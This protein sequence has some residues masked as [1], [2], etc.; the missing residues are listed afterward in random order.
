VT[1]RRYSESQDFQEGVRPGRQDGAEFA[2]KG[3]VGDTYTLLY[4]LRR[5]YR[6]WPV[7]AQSIYQ[8]HRVIRGLWA[9]SVFRGGDDEAERAGDAKRYLGWGWG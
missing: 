7:R 4:P 1:E 3:D 6:T 9:Q 2:E 8:Q 5:T